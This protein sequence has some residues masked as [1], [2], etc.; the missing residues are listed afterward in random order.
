MI[1]V[2][3]HPERAPRTTTIA[4]ATEHWFVADERIGGAQSDS[5]SIYTRSGVIFVDPLPLTYAAADRF[6]AVSFALLTRGCHQRASWRYRFEH[7]A[8]IVAPRGSWDLLSEP[9][10]H[11]VEGTPLPADFRAIRTPGPEWDHYSLYRPGEPSILFIGD[12]VTRRDSSSPL[13]LSG[14]S[15]RLRPGISRDSLASL[16]DLEFDL[17]CMSH[18]GYIDDD[19]KGALVELYERTA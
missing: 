7:G 18:G 8:R 15:A 2:N 11:Y 19:P 3:D 13:Q 4:D 9:D 17:L 14:D 16:L 12:L 6:P 1:G 10:R 5:Y